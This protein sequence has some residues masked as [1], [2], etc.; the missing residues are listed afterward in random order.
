MVASSHASMTTGE[1]CDLVQ[2]CV[3]KA[4]YRLPYRLLRYMHQAPGKRSSESED[5]MI[6]SISCLLTYMG[7]QLIIDRCRPLEFVKQANIHLFMVFFIVF[8]RGES[9]AKSPNWRCWVAHGLSGHGSSFRWIFISGLHTW[10][11]SI[12][13]RMS[14]TMY[15]LGSSNLQGSKWNY[16]KI[17]RFWVSFTRSLT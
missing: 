12:W 9:V 16:H 8:I 11:Y 4:S 5:F 17:F 15:M 1:L 13:S 7:R 14:H 3:T 10:L 6:F 2:P